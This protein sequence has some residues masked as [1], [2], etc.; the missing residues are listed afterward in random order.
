M[1][2][3]N[4]KWY[5]NLFNNRTFVKVDNKWIDIKN[6][7]KG[8]VTDVDGKWYS[9]AICKCG[10]VLTHSNSFIKERDLGNYSVFDY[11][12]SNCGELCYQNPDIA[13]FL[14]PCQH[15]GTPL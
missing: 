4:K 11:K 2:L 8:K 1:N 9:L 3:L 6:Y 10:N 5:R 7:K 13:P 15:D 12:C 14:M